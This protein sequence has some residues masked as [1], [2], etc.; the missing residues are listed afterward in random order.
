M[1]YKATPYYADGTVGEPLVRE[2]PDHADPVDDE[3]IFEFC[4]KECDG[5]IEFVGVKVG[6]SQTYLAAVNEDGIPL[7]LPVNTRFVPLRGTVVVISW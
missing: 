5:H 7:D 4:R 1:A 2:L 6:Q 3:E